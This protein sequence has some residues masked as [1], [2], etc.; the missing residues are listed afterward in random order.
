MAEDDPGQDDPR[1]TSIQSFPDRE[2]S[3]VDAEVAETPAPEA[4]PVTAEGYEQL[5]YELER[6]RTQARR[7]LSESLREARGEGDVADN[8]ALFGLF[9]EQTQLERRIAMLEERAALAQVVAPAADGTAGIGSSVRVRDV[10]LCEVAEYEL[11]GAIEA[12]ASIGRLSV[13]APVGRALVGRR[14]GESVDVETPGGSLA[15]EI[16]IVRPVS[17]PQSRAKKAA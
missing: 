5:C 16:L 1:V 8:P 13:V 2:E 10:A 4:L 12:D 9:E 15:F 7:E 3:E 6:L 17:R 14:A 11:V